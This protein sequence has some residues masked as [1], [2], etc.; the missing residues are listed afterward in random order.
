MEYGI[1][2]DL[3]TSGFRAHAVDLKNNKIIS[4][5]IT[6]CHPLPGA[7][8]MD[9]LTFSIKVGLDVAHGVAIDTINKLIKTL[10]IDLK[11]VVRM[12]LCGNPIQL[13]IAQNIPVDDLAFAGENA[14]RVRGIQEQKRDAGV[15]EIG[16][17]HV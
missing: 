14:K 15:F 2:L 9:H 10:G 8:I 16:R 1:S 7:N 12:S 3:G 4:T 6:E 5:S 11:D 17:A 13:S